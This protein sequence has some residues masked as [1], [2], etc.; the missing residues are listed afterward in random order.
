M[1]TFPRLLSVVVATLILFQSAIVAPAINLALEVEPAALM[2]RFLWPI[3]FALIGILGIIGV[4]TTRKQ[5]TGLF[6][7]GL[8][9]LGMAVC[10][11]LVPVIN[12]AKDSDNMGL[13]NALHMIT[14]GLTLVLLIAHLG[15]VFRWYRRV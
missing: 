12:K 6:V 7:N 11:F 13:W 1:V 4:V 2:L 5:R 14:V 3:F 10:Y 8:T 15:Y 9:S